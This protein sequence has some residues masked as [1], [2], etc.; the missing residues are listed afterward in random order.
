M[1]CLTSAAQIKGEKTLRVRFDKRHNLL[2][3]R[4]QNGVCDKARRGRGEAHESG[5]FKRRS[6]D[7]VSKSSIIA[8]LKRN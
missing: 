7:S 4:S 1:V 3:A 6:Q 2:M 5:L 8:G